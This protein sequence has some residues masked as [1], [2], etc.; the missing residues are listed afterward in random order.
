MT[1][2]F[3]DSRRGPEAMQIRQ[4]GHEE[5]VKSSPCIINWLADVLPLVAVADVLSCLKAFLEYVVCGAFAVSQLN[6]VEEQDGIVVIILK[7]VLAR[8]D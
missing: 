6:P 5:A 4:S 3:A 1:D 2:S 7:P 8:K